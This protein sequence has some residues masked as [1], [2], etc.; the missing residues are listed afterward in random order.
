MSKIVC[1]IIMISKRPEF[2]AVLEWFSKQR[3]TETKGVFSDIEEHQL[4][5]VAKYMQPLLKNVRS[6]KVSHLKKILLN[7]KEHPLGWI[8]EEILKATEWLFDEQGNHVLE[9]PLDDEGNPDIL[10]NQ[11]RLGLIKNYLGLLESC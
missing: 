8:E 9:Y 7:L 10:K 4:G 1:S 6:L 3:I 5:D 11:R 2:I